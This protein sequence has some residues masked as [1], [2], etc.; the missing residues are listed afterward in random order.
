MDIPTHPSTKTERRVDKLTA[1][2][3]PKFPTTAKCADK[4]ALL[5]PAATPHKLLKQLLAPNTTTRRVFGNTG[6]K[7]SSTIAASLKISAKRRYIL[8]SGSREV[9]RR[10]AKRIVA[11][12]PMDSWRTERRSAE[13]GVAVEEPTPSPS[14]TAREERREAI[15]EEKAWSESLAMGQFHLR[16]LI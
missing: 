9:P 11:M 6:L 2:N 4:L 15:E 10:E 3:S 5:L 12:R 16:M 7:Q 1:F 14:R 13:V 8:H